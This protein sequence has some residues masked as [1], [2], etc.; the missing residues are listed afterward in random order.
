M[1]FVSPFKSGIAGLHCTCTI[2]HKC[3]VA[4]FI[5]VRSGSIDGER[6]PLFLFEDNFDPASAS[7]NASCDESK[8]EGEIPPLSGQGR[9]CSHGRTKFSLLYR[10]HL[11]LFLFFLELRTV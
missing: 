9:H 6:V 1:K 3:E 11:L 5:L 4:C 8:G 10:L 7:V 2:K